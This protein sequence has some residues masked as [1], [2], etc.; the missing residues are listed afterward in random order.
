MKLFTAQQIRDWDSYTMQEEPIASIDL[1]E[2]AA[3]A[4]V[5]WLQHRFP[6]QEFYTIFCGKG[7]NGG[8]GLAIARLLMARNCSVTVYIPES[9]QQGSYDFQANLERLNQVYP[10]LIQFIETPEELPLVATGNIIIDAILG[11]GINRPVTGF[12][13]ALFDYI[14]SLSNVVVAIDMPSGLYADKAGDN[15]PVIEADHTLSFQGYKRALLMADNARAVGQVH[16]LPIGLDPDYYNQTNTSFEVIDAALIATI[17]KPRLRFAHKGSYGHGLLIAGSY[18]K[19]GAAVLSA[20]AALRSGI[21]LLTCYIPATSYSILQGNVPEAM[22][23][24]DAESNQISEPELNTEIYTSIGIGPGIGTLSQTIN[25]LHHLL[26]QYRHPMVIDADALNILGLH[27]GW[28]TLIPANS[29]LT[30][31]PKE[32]ERLFGAT[33]NNFT[34]QQLALEKAQL[35]NCIII[36]KG[37][38]S[39][40]ATPAGKGFYNT[41]GNAGM[42]TGGSGDVLTGLLTGLLAQGYTPEDAAIFGVYL[43]GLAGDLAAAANSMEAMTAGDIIEYLGQSFQQIGRYGRS[44]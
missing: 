22:V 13:A 9:E 38:H 8:D 10:E 31:H 21:G 12:T 24:T 34:Q 5:D 29:I 6:K 15:N 35:L 17:Y 44:I 3:T 16:V 7:N 20:K 4:C 42:A 41:T 39:F 23:I 2:R 26:Q 14:N 1:M 32:F 37:H 19:T 25:A 28:Q 36:V 33:T 30:P 27:K 40:I 18:G 43:H 11:T